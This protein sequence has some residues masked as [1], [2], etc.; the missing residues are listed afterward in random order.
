MKRSV[1][2]FGPTPQFVRWA[3][4]YPCPLRELDVERLPDTTFRQ[5]R[6]LREYSTG[7]LENRV[8]EGICIHPES[9][10]ED[11]GQ[12]RGFKADEVLEV[13]GDETFVA[14]CCRT[15]PA[16]AVKLSRPGI[17]AGCY[18][19]LP[20]S[21]GFCV[22]ST[23][24]QTSNLDSSSKNQTTCAP[25][26]FDFVRLFDDA[27]SEL[28]PAS[29]ENLF[30]A[31]TPRWY[32]IWK[33]STLN[34]AQLELLVE[35][36]ESIVSHCVDSS[37]ERSEIADL[38]QFRD[39]LIQSKNHRL[40]LHVELVPPGVSDGQT[41]TLAAHCPN[42][43]HE[44]SQTGPGLCSAC[45]RAGNPHGHRKSKVLGL[46][47]YINLADVLGDAMTTRLLKRFESRPND[48]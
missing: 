31:T 18:G 42:C 8:F 21:S 22:D 16:N 5:L 35:I 45:G 28:A 24:R 2:I 25:G 14:N 43:K 38:I 41:W 17:W 13:H 15:C 10:P 23:L 27:I 12:A 20:S 32:G 36:L 44:M 19:W 26:R 30:V 11:P 33:N 7:L 29:W 1:A 47:P 34:S 48:V 4:E 6:G 39:A 3:L 37:A 46:R 40:K 9:L